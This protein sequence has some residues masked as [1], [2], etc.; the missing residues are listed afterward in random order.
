[1]KPDRI[2]SASRFFPASKIPG[3]SKRLK[4][5]RAMLENDGSTRQNE[6]LKSD[7]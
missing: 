3:P 5:E 7:P 4:H 6:I 2:T 1:M